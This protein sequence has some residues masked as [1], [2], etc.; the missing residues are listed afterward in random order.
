MSYV[1]VFEITREAIPLWIPFGFLIFGLFCVIFFLGTRHDFGCTKWFFRG[2]IL[3]LSC[4]L[5]FFAAYYFVNQKHYV[6]AYRDGKYKAVE[7]PVEHYSRVGKHECFSLRGVEFCHGTANIAGWYPP[8]R[9][10]PT[11]WPIGLMGEDLPVRVVYTDEQYPKILRLD[12]G[13][14]SR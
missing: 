11:T 12:V 14:N 8:L 4:V 6:Q 9:V 3:L 2:F 7:G 5:V 10:G 1:T 13:R